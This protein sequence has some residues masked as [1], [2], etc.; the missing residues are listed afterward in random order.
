MDYLELG[1]GPDHVPDLVRLVTDERFDQ[2]DDE[3]PELW[4]P[5]HAWR[6]LGQLRAEPAVEPLLELA[7]RLAEDDYAQSE[8]GIVLGMI[9][10]AALPALARVVTD[11]E[12]NPWVRTVAVNGLDELVKGDESARVE[13]VPVLLAAM[14]KWEGNDDL[15]NAYLVDLLVELRVVEAAPLMEQAFAADSVDVFLRGDWED[16]QVELGLL[17]KRR[18][19]SPRRSLFPKLDPFAGAAVDAG[20]AP[21]RTPDVARVK[22]NKRK[23]Q[24][25]SRKKNRRRK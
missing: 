9:G 12:A 1:L 21:L 14:E 11:V 13:V 15:V 10:R 25:E 18:T 5:V 7:D 20:P 24:K 6:A 16:V 3:R 19:T 8:L 22:K 23:Q 17:E 2:G 4:A